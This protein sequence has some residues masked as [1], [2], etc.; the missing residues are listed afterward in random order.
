MSVKRVILDGSPEASQKHS[1]PNYRHGILF[2]GA[3]SKSRDIKAEGLLE[4][5]VHNSCFEVDESLTGNI[6]L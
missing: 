3:I 6:I 4:N 5:G 2:A 1:S